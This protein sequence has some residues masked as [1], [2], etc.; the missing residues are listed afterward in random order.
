MSLYESDDGISF[1]QRD[2]F[3]LQEAINHTSSVS[4]ERE[5]ERENTKRDEAEL[6]S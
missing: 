1:L 4:P 5:S 6:I 3:S 2:H